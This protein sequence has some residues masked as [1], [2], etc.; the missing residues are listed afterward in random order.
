M[1]AFLPPL[2]G[3]SLIIKPANYDRRVAPVAQLSLPATGT[4]A[5]SFARRRKQKGKIR[6]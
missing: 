6:W 1:A 4:L 5:P 2:F 3:K